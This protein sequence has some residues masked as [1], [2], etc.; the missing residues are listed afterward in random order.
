M[1]NFSRCKRCANLY[2]WWQQLNKHESKIEYIKKEQKRIF[3]HC[4]NSLNLN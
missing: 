2:C 1:Y 3:S 4:K